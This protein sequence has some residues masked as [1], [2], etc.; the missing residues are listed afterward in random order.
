MKGQNKTSSG[1][2][3]ANVQLSHKS[4]GFLI[5]QYAHKAGRGTE[6]QEA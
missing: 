5:L 3:R 2:H 6:G 1:Y 4:K